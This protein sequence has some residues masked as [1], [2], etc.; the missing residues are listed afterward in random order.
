MFE[1]LG[2]EDTVEPLICKEEVAA[3]RGEVV[4]LARALCRAFRDE[5]P[6]VSH[7]LSTDA[8]L[9]ELRDA[10]HRLEMASWFVLKDNPKL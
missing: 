4:G 5:H 2:P 10:V 9:L 7:D 8:I 1:G 6:I 3:I